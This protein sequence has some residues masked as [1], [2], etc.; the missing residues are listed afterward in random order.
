MSFHWAGRSAKSGAPIILLKNFSKVCWKRTGNHTIIIRY[1]KGSWKKADFNLA[2]QISREGGPFFH[3]K[4][5]VHQIY[6]LKDSEATTIILQI[7]SLSKLFMLM[8]M[9]FRLMVYFSIWKLIYAFRSISFFL[10]H[11]LV[12]L[13][14][15][16]K[17]FEM[18]YL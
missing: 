1:M 16:L 8:V 6:F 14:W 17:P 4:I 18:C 2:T 7:L 13:V 3:C 12:T 10:I 11:R 5:A 9:L 15:S